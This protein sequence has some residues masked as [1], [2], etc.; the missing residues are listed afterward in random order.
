MSTDVEAPHGSFC[1]FWYTAATC[2]LPPK[3]I[4]L[5]RSST[6][7][8]TVP[9]NQEKRKSTKSRAKDAEATKR[10]ILRAALR[11]FANNGYGGAR[12]D[13][14][15]D[16]TNTSKRMIYYYFSSKEGL[17]LAVLKTSYE[18]IREFEV[19]LNLD[20]LAPVVALRKLVETTVDYQASHADF[21]RIIMNENILR[22]ANIQRLPELKSV[23]TRAIEV[24]EKL[25]RRGIDEGVFRQDLDPLD[26]HMNISA[27][28]FF[29][30]SNQHTFGFIFDRDF[31][32]EDFHA[33]RRAQIVDII[34][35]F[36]RAS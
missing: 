23:N 27:L 24:L 35:R 1:T 30:V 14:I 4:E 33:A 34:V 13:T 21:I 28:S 18:Q 32:D 31:S 16:L 22:G 2:K 7:T 10:D 15:A 3:R 5:M 17:Y 8:G 11:E 6:T 25:C 9:V 19:E 29:N 12:V 36:A 26:L 20:D